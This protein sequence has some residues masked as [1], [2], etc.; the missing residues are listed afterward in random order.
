MDP[1]DLPPLPPWRQRLLRLAL[2]IVVVLALAGLASLAFEWLQQRL[3]MLEGGAAA[4]AM[5]G[6]IVLMLVAYAVLLAVPFMPGVEI[7]IALMM[8]Q[9]ATMAPFVYL[10]TLSGL[11]LAYLAGCLVPLTALHRLVQDVGW[12][13][14]CLW[15]DRLQGT[16][17]AERP[18]LMAERLPRW[19]A[20]V[21][22]N[23]RY[24]TLA[25][26]LNLPGNTALGGGGGLMLIAGLSGMFRPVGVMAMLALAVAPVPLVVWLWGAGPL[27]D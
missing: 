11:A 9:G 18:A 13:T 7:G 25:V 10:A 5:I 27:L 21:L 20:P 14:A 8:L 16:P 6:L 1:D 22:L 24:L 4:P 17:P 12:R 23:W 26:L 19:L 3:S 2:R 15:I